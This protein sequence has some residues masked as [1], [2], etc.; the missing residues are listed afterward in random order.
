MFESARKQT[1]DGKLFQFQVRC[2]E[3]EEIG[4]EDYAT[5]APNAS[6]LLLHQ[7]NDIGLS[8][9]SIMSLQSGE[10][11]L[12]CENEE[13]ENDHHNTTFECEVP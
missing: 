10:E 3:D 7:R 5:N 11:N 9:C 12:D 13:V 4:E 2:R 6:V 8:E 1:S